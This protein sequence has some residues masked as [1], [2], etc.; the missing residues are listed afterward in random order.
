MK[1][2]T[3]IFCISFLFICCKTLQTDNNLLGE[4]F[5]KGKDYEY[6]LMLQGDYS[7]ELQLKYQDA[8]P[9][10]T[11]SWKLVGDKLISLQCKEFSDITET[12]T[13]GYMSER[14]HNLEIINS[15]RLKFKGVILRKRK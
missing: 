14:E 7:F 13:N 1:I 8:S 15:N 9:K 10:C 3:Q 5:S 12:L 2:V 4:Y 11:G 6:I